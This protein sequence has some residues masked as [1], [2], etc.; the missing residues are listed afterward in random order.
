MCTHIRN[1][2]IPNAKRSGSNGEWSALHIDALVL[3][4]FAEKP[5]GFLYNFSKNVRFKLSR[6]KK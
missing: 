6:F 3:M 4:K 2:S 5:V 1:V